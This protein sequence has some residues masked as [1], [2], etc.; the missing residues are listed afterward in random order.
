M[1]VSRG[2]P[3]FSEPSSPSVFAPVATGCCYRSAAAPELSHCAFAPRV[4]GADPAVGIHSG[5]AVG[6]LRTS[7]KRVASS[8]LMGEGAVLVGSSYS[9]RQLPPRRAVL[10]GRRP[11]GDGDA[12]A[13]SSQELRVRARHDLIDRLVWFEGCQ[14]HGKGCASIGQESDTNLRAGSRPSCTKLHWCQ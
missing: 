12:R 1:A 2:N 3:R 4:E 11:S 9:P 13:F 14:T 7:V 8:H 5:S 6:P 10:A